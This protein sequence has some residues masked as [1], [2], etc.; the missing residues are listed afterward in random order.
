LQPPCRAVSLLWPIWTPYRR[1]DLTI[2][3]KHGRTLPLLPIHLPSQERG[4]FS[5]SAQNFSSRWVRRYYG[6]VKTLV[7]LAVLGTLF[8]TRLGFGAE[9]VVLTPKNFRRLAPTGK[10]ADAIAGDLLLSNRKIAVVVA[11]S[12]ADRHAHVNALKVGGAVLDLTSRTEPN[13]QLTAFFPGSITA[14]GTPLA[15]LGASVS[16]Q[17][18]AAVGPSS[19]V[20]G[21]SVTLIFSTAAS[22][23][24]VAREVRYTLGD[25]WD[26]L[27]VET[28]FRNRG[29]EPVMIQLSDSFRIDNSQDGRSLE[30][31]ANGPSALFW[32]NDKW[33]G[34]AYGLVSADSMWIKGG[35]GTQGLHVVH[36]QIDG[37]A[38]QLW[39]GQPITLQ[40]RLFA[41]RN[42]FDLRRIAA[43]AM[44]LPYRPAM[45][46]VRDQAG[47]P[48][49]E[50]DVDLMIGTER[51][52]TGRTDN[53]GQ[54]VLQLPERGSYISV[55][56]Q[57]H[58]SPVRVVLDEQTTQMNVVLQNAGIL[59]GSIVDGDNKPVP[60]MVQVW[61]RLGVETPFFGPDSGTFA[62]WDTIHTAN[63]KISQKL[64]PGLYDII[65][66][67]GP[68]Y[69]AWQSTLEIKAGNATAIEVKLARV[70][71]S[72]G[73]L[74]ADFHGHAT[75]SGDNV[76]SQLGRVLNLLVEG[77][78]FAPA[79]EHN[80]ISSYTPHLL[81]LGALD[82]L[83]TASGMEL[84]GASLS[85]SHHNAFPLVHKP[86]LQ[87]GGG[88]EISTDP[89][90]QLE[91]LSRWDNNSEKLI[92]Q[93]HADLG[94][95]FY[96]RDADGQRDH[97]HSH[98]VPFIDV[99][100]INPLEAVFWAPFASM[101]P[102]Y[103]RPDRALKNRV[104]GWLQMLNQGYRLPAVSNTD[105]HANWHGSGYVRNYVE[106]P[107][108]L[109]ALVKTL[110][111]IHAAEH[112]HMVMTNGPFL[113]VSAVNAAGGK[114]GPGDDLAATDGRVSIHIK[115]QSPNWFGVSRVRVLV[116]GRT[117]P[118]L[119]FSRA[120]GSKGFSDGAV[121]YEQTVLLQLKGDAHIV[122]ITTEDE[123][124]F[125]P[126]RG[127]YYGKDHPAALSNPVFVD[128]D[129]GGF[130]A[131]G[132]TLD[133]P[134]SNP[135]A[136]FI[137]L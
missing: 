134:L 38:V 43:D 120:Q 53:N 37:G 88:P 2:V 84:T 67:H 12:R 62:M 34:Q 87:N 46:S 56:A 23:D 83:A 24:P 36:H 26:Y 78:E 17:P 123:H 95:L 15:L 129:G 41:G 113:E 91:R 126:I 29:S 7:R 111:V 66:S 115:V 108:D 44:G 5:R 75:E 131:N 11:A 72:T 9:I 82:K 39:P 100:E 71:Q 77:I 50:A 52:A 25:D 22:P 80:R 110:D 137:V 125:G 135:A 101:L 33:F 94:R 76:S 13:D 118:E 61:G 69:D 92:Q 20:A 60:A 32:A 109:P 68:E 124:P 19:R 128:V 10:E 55:S 14:E 117:T 49:A 18:I 1:R 127:P 103:V 112:G 65:V 30:T 3:T 73:W 74:S 99:V 133:Q 31:A 8:A 16:G 47:A 64:A 40:R 119:D 86:L 105:A 79:T 130:K 35:R 58:G 42:L 6:R 89:E 104:F 85:L 122:V 114:A 54:L 28:T 132:D 93:N 90:V 116:N 59:Q 51:Y 81:A 102:D 136:H 97:G 96:D 57:G 48:V 45:V 21:P 106:S 70:V 63:G 98:G 27:Q 107:T 4:G 121:Q